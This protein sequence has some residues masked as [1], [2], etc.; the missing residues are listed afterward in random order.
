MPQ[1]T[2][3]GVGRIVGSGPRRVEPLI[4]DNG[5]SHKYAVAAYS[6]QQ[7]DIDGELTDRQGSQS[8]FFGSAET[9]QEAMMFAVR[10][11]FSCC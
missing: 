7:T 11:E 3:R 6:G 1:T 8:K 10:S 5:Q 2:A 4:E 9:D